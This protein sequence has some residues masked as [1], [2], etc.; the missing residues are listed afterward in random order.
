LTLR[1]L[2]IATDTH[3][4][5]IALLEDG[6]PALVIEEERL[7]RTRHTLRF[8]RH[9]LGAA[10]P[11]GIKD[12]AGI[13]AIATPWDVRRLRR[14]FAHA[15]FHRLPQSLVLLRRDA[16]PMQRSE[17]VL[18]NL[19]I[20]R[21][22]SR[23]L[24][25][26]PLPPIVNVPHHDAHAAI[27]FVSP[28]EESTVLVM[29]G[30][31]DESATS[32]YSAVGGRVERRWKTS[33]FDS[34]G[35]LYTFLTHYLGFHGIGQEGKVMAL[36]AYGDETYIARFRE[37]VRLEPDGRYRLDMSYF[38]FDAHGLLRPFRLKFLDAFGPP[39]SPMS[40]LED[41]HRAIARA[42]QVTTEEAI[43]HVVRGLERSLPSR[44]LVLTGGVA[45]NCVA[46]GRVKAETGFRNVWVPPVASDTG[47]PL[48]AA[49][50]HHHHTLGGPRNFTLTHAAL[51]LA[52]DAAE[53]RRA[54]E[55]AGLVHRELAGDDLV[56]EVARDLAAGRIV[57][58]FQG[59]FE[60]GPRALG[61]RSILADPRNPATRERMNRKIKARE[62]FRPF[63]PAILAE[64]ANEYFE[65]DGPDPYMTIAP[66]ARAERAGEIPAAIHVDGTGRIQT[67][68][69]AH[70]PRFHAL[71]SAFAELTGVPVL[72]NTSFNKHEPIV[73]RPE[74]AVSCFLRTEMDVLAIG[75]FYCTR[76]SGHSAG[77]SARHAGA[78]A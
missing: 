59:R 17:I 7:S 70:N 41:R 33:I 62:E 43:L 42:L 27:Y 55:A 23:W 29:D 25:A 2:G 37:L 67:V 56:R 11:G 69:R 58:W 10:F 61:F 15:V 34:I 51:G 64:R 74:E 45:L 73:A 5:G 50:W 19:R 76:P 54:I 39:R 8:P 26:G 60:I 77:A 4:S 52:Y 20:R 44:N 78:E 12:L 31:G 36:A 68:D 75:D 30:Y 32:A 9:A 3:D 24:G 53:I 16:R 38:D 49:L 18:L 21:G 71:I 65:I 46:N 66:R 47:A 6:V 28:F 22:L 40:P 14:T 13:E 48:G 63:A 57:G 35:M 1:I 72:I